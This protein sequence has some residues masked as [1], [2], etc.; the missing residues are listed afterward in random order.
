MLC[1]LE[2]EGS[3][4][5]R[6]FF[7][8]QPGFL[9]RKR[10]DSLL[11]EAVRHTIVSVVAGPGYGKTYAV[12]GY[13]KRMSERLIWMRFRSPDNEILRFW[14]SFC[15]SMARELPALA[16]KTESVPFP[17]TPARYD[18]YLRLFTRELS[19]GPP[20]VMVV[21]NYEL[22]TT[23]QITQFFEW[24]AQ[25]DPANFCLVLISNEKIPL[26]SITTSSGHFRISMDDLKFTEEEASA[27][28][29]LHQIA[30]SAEETRR[31]TEET[32][33]WPLA[34]HLMCYRHSAGP[35]GVLNEKT[36]QQLA[37]ELFENA[38]FSGYSEATQQLLVKLSF[39]PAFPLALVRKISPPGQIDTT[40]GELSKNVFLEYNY[41]QQ[42]FTF[43]SMYREFLSH[44]QLLLDPDEVR[45]LHS[46]VGNWFLEH[47]HIYEAM[48]C[49][50]HIEDYDRFLDAVFQLPRVRK[51][52]A[53]TSTILER[54]NQIPAAY[55]DANPFVDF[56]RAFMLLN[57]MRVRK[58]ESLFLELLSRLEPLAAKD[59]EARLLAG[60]ICIALADISILTNRDSGLDYMKKA[61][62]Y[63][64]DGGRIRGRDLL[65]VGN[66]E[67]FF[68]PDSQPGSLAR[69]VDYF[70]E[71]AQYADT[72][73]NGSGYG[74]EW[75]FSAQAAYLT[76]NMARAKD[77]YVQALIK[78]QVTEQ[79]D[80]I[81]NAYWGMMRI[82]LYYGDGANAQS[83]LRRLAAHLDEHGVDY[84]S[85][86]RDCVESWF[87]IQ[88]RDFDK[89][90]AW[91]ASDGAIQTDLPLDLGRNVL[92]KAFYLFEK[93]DYA[94]SAAFLTGLEGLC[95]Q[96]GL[97]LERVLLY[98][99]KALRLLFLGDRRGAVAEF[100]TAYDMV[101]A[102]NITVP[103]LEFGKSM[104]RLID[105]V[106]RQSDPAFDMEWLDSVYKK[107]G[108]YHKRLVSMRKEYHNGVYPADNTSTIRLTAQER[109]VL[110]YLAQGLTRNEIAQLMN[111]SLGSVKKRITNIYTKLG[112]VNR[113][114]AIHIA[115]SNLLLE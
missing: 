85:E 20:V 108:S 56:S 75:L 98:T 64:P 21:D 63:L 112:A 53:A 48:D 50:W 25:S 76:E 27:L 14:G 74:F 17:E 42:V 28:F 5:N 78:A 49:F 11:E 101:Y 19:P 43:Q 84:L 96:K 94:A 38:Y 67:P 52:V 82:S 40:I 39:F 41:H 111:I 32:A 95:R 87:Y 70:F 71:Y 44:R 35:G 100:Q 69:M 36:H 88:M 51:S 37:A 104:Q 73:T 6:D 114:D 33:G 3:S 93:G 113:A 60:D 77:H 26:G 58:A 92:T 57:N 30:L 29:E 12:A 72:V 83:W 54:L 79:H 109:Q 90:A 47:G 97:W 31:I 15:T 59:H 4:M 18:A 102:N 106:R 103:F 65:V 115:T 81:C 34:L 105:A 8:E 1:R 45:H 22:A 13:V 46:N 2:K 89:V 107:S 16:A 61:A 7:P 24:L 80:I 62:R 23:P 55:R 68:L 91:V 10:L 99:M 86:L 66:D 110:A 9:H